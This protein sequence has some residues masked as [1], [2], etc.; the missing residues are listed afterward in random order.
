[1]AFRRIKGHIRKDERETRNKAIYQLWETKKS[2]L[3]QDDIGKQYGLTHQRIG[4]IIKRQGELALAE[5][6]ER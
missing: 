2:E 1:M 3:S 6:A 4:Q 5:E